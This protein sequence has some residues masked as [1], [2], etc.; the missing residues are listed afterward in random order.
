MAGRVVYYVHRIRSEQ[1][2][3]KV[4]TGFTEDLKSR[5]KHHNSGCCDFT[6][7][8]RPW[9]LVFYAA[10]NEKQKAADFERYLKS[11]SGRAFTKK[12]LP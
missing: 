4:Y 10:F 6:R 12:H 1:N 9:R 8:F 3:G 11:G 2:P 7:P 5:I